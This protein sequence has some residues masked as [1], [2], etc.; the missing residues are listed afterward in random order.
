[1]KQN[2]PT[3]ELSYYELSL[4]AFLKDSHPHRSEDIPFIQSRAELAAEAYEE[5]LLNGYV[6]NQSAEIANSTLFQDLH[7]SIHDTIVNI[8]WSEFADQVPQGDAPAVAV[9]LYPLVK[10]ITAKYL[11][12]DDFA[13][14]PE[15]EQL[16]TELTGA[17][18]IHFEE[19]GI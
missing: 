8:L 16:Y 1:M 17:I 11:M 6:H 5:A 2:I 3:I 14:G 12:N 18:L 15:Y 9:E 10:D 13:Y 19:Y 7:F 4:L